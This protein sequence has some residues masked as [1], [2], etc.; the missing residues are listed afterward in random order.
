MPDG[1]IKIETDRFSPAIHTSAERFM[2]EIE[3]LMGG[4]AIHQ[5]KPGGGHTHTHSD[6]TVHSHG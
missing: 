3:K 6:G 4:E 1:R 2:A 5:H